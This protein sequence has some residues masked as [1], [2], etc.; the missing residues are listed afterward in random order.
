MNA[1][2]SGGVN[3]SG[4]SCIVNEYD[5]HRGLK[6]RETYL[7]KAGKPMA[8]RAGIA[9]SEY[10]YN[11]KRQLTREA[12]FGLSGPAKGPAGTPPLTETQYDIAGHVIQTKVTDLQ[13]NVTITQFD[14]HG[15]QTGVSHQAA[16][17]KPKPQ[18]KPQAQPPA[19]TPAKPPAQPQPR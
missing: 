7:D 8:S 16:P 3:S 18:P 10:S 2:G 14:A 19:Q 13:G 12:Y 4:V 1:D 5:D 17:A 6:I 9:R 11:E 15:K